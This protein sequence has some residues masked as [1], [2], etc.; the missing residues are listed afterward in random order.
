MYCSSEIAGGRPL[1][2]GEARP[3]PKPA[4]NPDIDTYATI[5]KQWRPEFDAL[6]ALRLATGLEEAIKW[7]KP[8]YG[9]TV[10]RRATSEYPMPVELLARFGEDACFRD[11][12]ESL[13]PGRQRDYPLHVAGAKQSQ[14]CLDRIDRNTPRI[15]DGLGMHD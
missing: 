3:L 8:C 14:A 15:F 1:P 10:A 9:A 7:R 11:A 12:L 13:T 6:R 2:H 5:L 4:P